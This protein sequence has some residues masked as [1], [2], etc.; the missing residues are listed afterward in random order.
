MIV[1]DWFA[2]SPGR[3]TRRD[4]LAWAGSDVPQ[5]QAAQ[6]IPALPMM[7]RRRATPIGQKALAAALAC[8]GIDKAR[9]VLA[10]RHGEYDRTVN[11]LLSLA[12]DQQPSP[13]E[14]SMSVHHGLAGLLSIHTGNRLGHIAVAASL[15]SFGYGLLEAAS[16]L[17]DAPETPVLLL[18]VDAPLPDSYAP[19]RLAAEATLPVAVALLL[20]AGDGS[21][22]S[23]G[24]A[25]NDAGEGA[26]SLAERFLK[27]LLSGANGGSATGEHMVWRWSRAA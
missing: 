5:A 2:W 3:E 27:F 19:F 21:R 14:F 23:I 20:A 8:E 18:Y 25:A 9:Y 7:L 13:A 10:S 17:A 6:P 24:C 16:C 4:W 12:N 1:R 15:D 26:D 22:I 11:I